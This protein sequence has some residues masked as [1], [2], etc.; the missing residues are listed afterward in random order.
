MPQTEAIT[1]DIYAQ[2][3]T[4]L[5][6]AG[7]ALAVDTLRIY[8]FEEE[9]QEYAAWPQE[10]SLT[11]RSLGLHILNVQPKLLQ[12]IPVV[13]NRETDF[14]G[15]SPIDIQSFLYVPLTVKKRPWGCLA[16]LDHA[17]VREWGL[18]ELTTALEKARELE[19]LIERDQDLR[20]M[21]RYSEE[22]RLF[23]DYISD[24]VVRIDTQGR[25]VSCGGY[26]IEHGVLRAEDI[27]GRAYTDFLCTE[28]GE[29]VTMPVSYAEYVQRRR[30]V[31]ICVRSPNGEIRW[32]RLKG[33]PL[34]EQGGT[35]GMLCVL[36]DIHAMVVAQKAL[37]ESE[38][39]YRLLADSISDV[40]WVL[41]LKTLQYTYISP[42]DQRA[43]GYTLEEA[44]AQ[45]PEE[46]T[47]PECFQHLM[48]TL[49]EEW[50]LERSGM[51]P[52]NRSRS[53]EMIDFRKDGTSFRTHMTIS[54]IRDE[55]GEPVALLGVSRNIEDLKQA[56]D[57]LRA[58]ETKY[59][60]LAESLADVLAMVE[61]SGDITYI[62]PAIGKF[63]GYSAAEFLARCPNLKD[64]EAVLTEE[65]WRDIQTSG[66][67]RPDGANSLPEEG[68]VLGFRRQDGSVAWG[69]VS[70]NVLDPAQ[71]GAFGGAI[72]LVRDVTLG[73]LTDSMRQTIARRYPVG[74][75]TFGTVFRLDFNGVISALDEN[76]HALFGWGGA[77][78]TRLSMRDLLGVKQHERLMR[79]VALVQGTKGMGGCVEFTLKGGRKVVLVPA[80]YYKDA[81][82]AGILCV[83]RE[84][85]A[86]Y[87]L[88]PDDPRLMELHRHSH[89]VA[90]ITDA[91]LQTLYVSPS[92]TEIL[93]YEPAE[94]MTMELG[95]TYPAA[96]LARVV[97]AFDQGL[98]A[99]RTGTPWQTELPI[100]QRGKDG[101]S[102]S[103][104]LFIKSIYGT[105]RNL[106][107]F[108]GIT[109]M[110]EGL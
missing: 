45:S 89:E 15:T 106:R 18:G 47:T 73:K 55:H 66:F 71:S 103:G 67:P 26:L 63:L 27:V 65:S 28:T 24:M 42:S 44:M 36:T 34:R 4:L 69:Q 91:R 77:P 17:R 104:T 84:L 7:T 101:R 107:G 100:Q 35:R 68:V 39:Q 19:P 12:N 95:A 86:A 32:V 21:Q 22:Y 54:G 70:L 78:E 99:A 11:E 53:L 30:T 20:V 9:L 13:G 43:R 25:I 56:E 108:L 6:Q 61:T 97:K 94:A 40:V 41:D 76:T 98:A 105:K 8:A 82:P 29:P 48:Q 109:Y 110:K 72:V 52:P 3:R 81:V 62:S 79:E 5:E 64:L 46:C 96:V 10:A 37:R 60:I 74:Q 31:D 50:E 93:G 92:I 87:A 49:M 90:W 88:N 59:R 83:A 57:R 1:A 38:A 80:L 102:R 33:Y 85:R 75:G 23:A 14:L 58:S 51:A 16:F 2:I